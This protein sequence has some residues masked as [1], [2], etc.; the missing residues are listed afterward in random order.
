NPMDGDSGLQRGEHRRFF[1]VNLPPL[2]PVGPAK[3]LCVV[4]GSRCVAPQ[5][6]GSGI[7]PDNPALRV[8]SGDRY[9][10]LFDETGTGL[11]SGRGAGALCYSAHFGVG[12]FIHAHLALHSL[13]ERPAR[14][15]LEREWSQVCPV[16]LLTAATPMPRPLT[17]QSQRSLDSP[18]IERHL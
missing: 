3:S 12:R 5:G 18:T 14:T 17:L 10:K 4:A 9:R 8:T 1:T 15:P 16:C 2:K 11:K 7:E 13:P 6:N